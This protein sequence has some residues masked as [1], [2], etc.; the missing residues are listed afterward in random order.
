MARRDPRYS[1]ASLPCAG[2]K[3]EVRRGKLLGSE[4]KQICSEPGQVS[5]HLVISLPWLP[6]SVVCAFKWI[7][8][9]WSQVPS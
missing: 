9:I 2:G 8:Q 3:M 6:P 1:L 7:M 5:N 4:A